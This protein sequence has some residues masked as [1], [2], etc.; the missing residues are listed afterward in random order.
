[1]PKRER[2]YNE[3]LGEV[4]FCDFKWKKAT[5]RICTNKLGTVRPVV[6]TIRLHGAVGCG[7]CVW[8]TARC[9]GGSGAP[10]GKLTLS[11]SPCQVQTLFFLTMILD[12]HGLWVIYT[13]LARK[14]GWKEDVLK[15]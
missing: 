3:S 14:G 7:N 13:L 10:S 5:F 6:I 9:A 11:L 4:C 1:M 8:Q 15:T 2:E 12:D